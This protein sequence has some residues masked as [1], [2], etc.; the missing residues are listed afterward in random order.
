MNR[1]RGHPPP[2]LGPDRRIG[3]ADEDVL[4]I[5]AHRPQGGHRGQDAAVIVPAPVVPRTAEKGLLP[6]RV[7]RALHVDIAH[8]RVT[9]HD[10]RRAD[11]PATRSP[12]RRPA[13]PVSHEYLA[14]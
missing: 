6:Q 2:R 1:D 11:E 14:F 5:G 4:M 12:V 9:G 13:I 7:V 8:A 3:A 10:R